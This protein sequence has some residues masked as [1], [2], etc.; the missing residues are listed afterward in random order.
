MNRK[1]FKYSFTRI[2]KLCI[3]GLM[4]SLFLG[5][6]G[7]RCG[8]SSNDPPQVPTTSF[9]YEIDRM[10][11]SDNLGIEFIFSD[12][13]KRA[14]ADRALNVWTDD[15][16]IPTQVWLDERYYE[17]RDFCNNHRSVVHE[18]Y[19]GYFYICGVENIY[20]QYG[21][22]VAGLAI[23]RSDTV[24]E[25]VCAIATQHIGDLWWAQNPKPEELAFWYIA[26]ASAHE[27]G[28][29]FNLYHCGND[30]CIMEEAVNVLGT[31]HKEFCAGCLL[32]IGTDFP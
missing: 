12:E 28:H 4:L 13:F 21:N 24:G 22:V 26:W 14:N 18:T 2:F 16:N 32:A 6:K 9:L 27:I 20:N 31:V 10:T 23:W 19:D 5:Q 25:A 8:G 7:I 3:F 17:V 15:V 29:C 11:D 1:N 30:G